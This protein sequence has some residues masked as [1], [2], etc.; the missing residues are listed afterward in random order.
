MAR[1]KESYCKTPIAAD[2]E[3]LIL[4]YRALKS[5]ATQEELSALNALKDNANETIKYLAILSLKYLFPADMQE[6]IKNDLGL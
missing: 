6:T 1:T 4:L 3:N 2:E 5:K